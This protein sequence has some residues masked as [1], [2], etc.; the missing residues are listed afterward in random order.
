[1]VVACLDLEGVLFPEIWINVAEKTGISALKLTTRDISDYDKLM[2]HR[3]KILKKHNIKINKI[4]EVISTLN[5]IPGAKDFFCKLKKDFQ[6]IILSDTFYQF[7][8]PLM[9]QIDYPTIFCHN[10]II[11]NN[12]LVTNYELRMNDAKKN[13]VIKLKELNFKTIACGD[14]YN[15]TTM[16]AEA[17]KGILFK[18]PANVINDFPQY[19]VTENYDD[20]LELFLKFRDT[21]EASDE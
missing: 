1:M 21:L 11:N 17:D 15:D 13:S 12:G 8:M 6:V 10:L 4:K 3:L 7:A 2:R 16:L 18:P 20:L 9:K 19:P 5:P 14:S